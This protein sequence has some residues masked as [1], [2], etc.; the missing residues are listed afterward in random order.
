MNSSDIN[1]K[2]N[3]VYTNN[4]AAEL[5]QIASMR[6]EGLLTV[7]GSFS[8]ETGQHTGRS[9]KDKHI[10][11]DANTENEIWWDNNAKI[12][13][14]NF[15]LLDSDMNEHMA[16]KELFIQ[17]LYAGADL[18]ERI[19][20]R[21][22]TEFAWQAL[23]IQHLLI[24]PPRK[25]LDNFTPDLTIIDLPSFNTD[26]KKYGVRTETTIACDFLGGKIL[27]A[28]TYYAGEIKKSVFTYLNYTLPAKGIFPMHCSANVSSKGETWFTNY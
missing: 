19:K 15:E 9:P 11:C 2:V 25:E 13:R 17:D 4:S 24:L 8:V 16:G 10:I 6:A 18:K 23:F 5:I 27:I 3:R 12:T 14:E 21:V 7:D 22:I 1:S 26:P 20:V 28:G